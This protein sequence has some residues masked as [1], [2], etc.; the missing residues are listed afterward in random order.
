MRKDNGFLVMKCSQASKCLTNYIEIDWLLHLL[1]AAIDYI[2]FQIEGK[3]P[4]WFISILLYFVFCFGPSCHCCTPVHQVKS[5]QRK[6][7]K[8]ERGVWVAD[9]ACKHIY[10]LSK[11][12]CNFLLLCH[13]AAANLGL[14]YIN[15][16]VLKLT[17][18]FHFHFIGPAWW[19][20]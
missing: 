20:L 17:L 11:T 12:M 1:A 19:C 5:P 4:T 6:E 2:K 9:D 3:R 8:K 14:V 10:S 18:L 15:R 16:E 13:V 7:R